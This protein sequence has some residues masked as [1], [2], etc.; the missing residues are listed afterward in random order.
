MVCRLGAASHS[1][2]QRTAV[3]LKLDTAPP[4][5]GNDQTE[6]REFKGFLETRPLFDAVSKAGLIDH[7]W[8]ALSLRMQR[9]RLH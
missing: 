5:T 3:N 1:A 7:K 8:Y 9:G 2:H 4:L 6:E